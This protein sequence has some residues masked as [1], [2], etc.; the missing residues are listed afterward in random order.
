VALRSKSGRGYALYDRFNPAEP[1]AGG[2]VGA[3]RSAAPCRQWL[4]GRVTALT[5]GSTGLNSAAVELDGERMAVAP[6][7]ALLIPP[8][9]RHWAEGLMPIL[10]VVVPPFDPVDEWMSRG[11]VARPEAPIPARGPPPSYPPFCTVTSRISN[12]RR[13]HP[14]QSLH[15]M[16]RLSAGASISN[17]SSRAARVW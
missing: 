1:A 13:T 14:P 6:G 7:G 4:A 2:R 16:R 11:L 9:V 10:N 5:R 3:A 17:R 8:E 15:Q 12:S